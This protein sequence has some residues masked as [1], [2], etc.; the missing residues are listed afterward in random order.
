MKKKFKDISSIRKLI[1]DID[2]KILNLISE[3]KELVTEVVK[4]KSREQIID[5]KRIESMIKKL[6]KHGKEKNL[7]HGLV[8]K[9][10]RTMIMEFIT[11]EENIFD[12]I[13]KRN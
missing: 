12:D 8:D 1:D 9:L 11:Y 4:L 3:R 5:K 13:H 10:W 2:I 7:P 6:N